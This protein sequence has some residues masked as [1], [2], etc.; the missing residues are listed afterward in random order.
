[1]LLCCK[2][3]PNLREKIKN[4]AC[5]CC[6]RCSGMCPVS[7]LSGQDLQYANKSLTYTVASALAV[8]GAVFVRSYRGQCI[9]R[10]IM[11]HVN[12]PSPSSPA[13][14]SPPSCCMQGGASVPRGGRRGWG[15]QRWEAVQ[16]IPR[17][18]RG[19][20]EHADSTHNA[21][22]TLRSIKPS[23]P[24]HT[25]PPPLRDH[26]PAVRSGLRA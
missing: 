15:A 24:R 3:N 17:E 19:G 21:R 1:M 7:M 20:E 18:G 11:F 12:S 16:T 13:G 9:R 5:N 23:P 14:S 10:T 8:T 25:P 2:N 26:S 4:Q 6:S 22:A